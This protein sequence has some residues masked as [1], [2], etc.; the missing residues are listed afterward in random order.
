M[1]RLATL[2]QPIVAQAQFFLIVLGWC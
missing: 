1:M 2:D